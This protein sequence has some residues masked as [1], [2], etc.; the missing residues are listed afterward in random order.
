[1]V[2]PDLP[3]G[4]DEP[5]RDRSGA[6]SRRLVAQALAGDVGPG[7]DVSAGE[8][9]TVADKWVTGADLP[10]HVRNGCLEF[11]VDHITDHDVI[12]IGRTTE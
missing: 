8:P 1:M 3:L 2:P 10:T 6:P 5:D 9:I 4:R 7:S 12:V 11:R